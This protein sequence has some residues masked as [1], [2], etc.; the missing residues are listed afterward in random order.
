MVQSYHC[1][2]VKDPPKSLHPTI[3]VTSSE[4]SNKDQEADPDFSV[5]TNCVEHQSAIK[6]SPYYGHSRD[7]NVNKAYL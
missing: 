3:Q 1:F 7:K 2:E 6:R 4:D 5:P